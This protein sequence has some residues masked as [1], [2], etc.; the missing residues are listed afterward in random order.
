M[1][2]RVKQTL[3]AILEKFKSGDMPE[4]IAL[5]T[6]LTSNIPSNKWSFTNRTIMFLSG[7]GDAR[8]FQQWKE[9]NRY[10][11]KGAKAVYILAPASENRLMREPAK[12]HK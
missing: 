2:E 11:K 1:N 10:V 5:A 8:G 12:R 7:T 9:V 4:A 3:G 6:F